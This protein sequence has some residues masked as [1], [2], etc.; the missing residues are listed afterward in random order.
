MEIETKFKRDDELWVVKTTT[1]PDQYIIQ[2]PYIIVSIDISINKGGMDVSYVTNF[3]TSVG[4]L[5][6]MESDKNVFGTLEQAYKKVVRNRKEKQ[7]D[8]S[9]SSS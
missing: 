2:G 9:Q 6:L 4:L 1:K 8:D 5:K 3:K 7:L